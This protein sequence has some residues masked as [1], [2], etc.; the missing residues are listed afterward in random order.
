[1]NNK[2]LPVPLTKKEINWGIRYLLFQLVFLG[3][4]LSWGLPMIFPQ[5]RSIHID[6]VYFV[7][8][9]IAV[10]CIFYHFL[11]LSSKHGISN[12]SKLLLTSGA[13]FVV[14]WMLIWGLNSVIY[15]LYPDFQ[16]I[17]DA[18]IGGYVRENFWITAIGTVV[19]VPITEE[20][21]FRGLIFGALRQRS[22]ML[23]YLVCVLTFALIHVMGYFAEAPLWV[24][25]LC[26]LQYIPAG[27]VLT[28]SYEYSGSILAPTLIHTTVNAIAIISMR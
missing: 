5:V 2:E 1:M 8:N 22:R 11:G 26:L 7:I 9:F 17:N 21:L 18:S 23:A 14:Y 13:G 10:L 19:L 25:L 16:N 28:W 12:W 27:L 20:V 4:F 24:L 15:R 3:S 6:T